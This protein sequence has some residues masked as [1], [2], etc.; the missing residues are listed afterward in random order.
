LLSFGVRGIGLFVHSSV[1]ENR[2]VKPLAHVISALLLLS[3]FVLAAQLSMSPGNQPW[4]MAKLVGLVAYV[5]LGIAAF[6]VP[7][8]N[9]RRLL[10][11]GAL[12][13]FA[14]IVSVAFSKNP[15]GF[16]G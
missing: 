13:V 9:A 15:L 5:G 3:G 8:P 14:Y 11:V 6:R 7:N 4:L 10:W 16:L 1:L 2:W 12:V